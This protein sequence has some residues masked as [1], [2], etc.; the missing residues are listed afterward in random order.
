VD[1]YFGKYASFI[2]DDSFVEK[3]GNHL[4][5]SSYHWD[6]SQKKTVWRQQLVTSHLVLNSVDLPLFAVVFL[7]EDQIANPK[8]NDYY[9]EFQSKIELAIGQIE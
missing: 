7:K 9:T 8:Q 3:F 4:P 6:H 1:Q 5:G 2:L